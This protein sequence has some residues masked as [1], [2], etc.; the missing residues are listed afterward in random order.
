M[1][2]TCW[3]CAKGSR[4]FKRSAWGNFSVSPTWSTRPTTGRGARSTSL[5]A[6]RNLFWQLSKRRKLAWRLVEEGS[7][8]FLPIQVQRI[9]PL[10]H[11]RC[12]VC[13]YTLRTHGFQYTLRTHGFHSSKTMYILV[14]LRKIKVEL[15][16]DL[17]LWR[18][19]PRRRGL[20]GRLMVDSCTLTGGCRDRFLMRTLYSTL[21][22]RR[23]GMRMIGM[24][25]ALSASCLFPFRLHASLPR[26]YNWLSSLKFPW[27]NYWIAGS[28]GHKINMDKTLENTCL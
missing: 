20:L 1:N 9:C 15:H 28:W 13:T 14:R 22:R 8:L 3:L 6:H 7:V 5:F 24:L 26:T 11:V 23:C 18:L 2:P 21:D 27:E 17:C 25:L 19:F 10:P 12:T 4:L 16:H